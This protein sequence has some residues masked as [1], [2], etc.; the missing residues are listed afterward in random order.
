MVHS[1][2]LR[3]PEDHCGPF[4]CCD[5]AIIVSLELSKCLMFDTYIHP[6]V[7]RI[8]DWGSCIQSYAT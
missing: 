5:E 2:S 8:E 4:R 6:I 3:E 1:T 7:R